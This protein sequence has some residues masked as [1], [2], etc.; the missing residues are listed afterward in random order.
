MPRSGRIS[1]LGGHGATQASKHLLLSGILLGPGMGKC[2]LLSALE[3]K[4]DCVCASSERAWA[5]GQR[6]A[7]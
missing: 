6:W 2:F 5:R 4:S 7:L 3:T 1:Y